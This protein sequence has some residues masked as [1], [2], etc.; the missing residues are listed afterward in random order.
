MYRNGVWEFS[1]EYH[2]RVEGCAR[3]QARKTKSVC[4]SIACLP[5]LFAGLRG[6]TVARLTPDQKVACSNHVG[7]KAR[8]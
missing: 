4:S 3:L 1:S 8:F 6:A 5:L 2:A 7:V